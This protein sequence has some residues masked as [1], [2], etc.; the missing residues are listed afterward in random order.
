VAEHIRDFYHPEIDKQA[1]DMLAALDDPTVAAAATAG[2]LAFRAMGAKRRPD[3]DDGEVWRFHDAEGH[4]AEVEFRDPSAIGAWLADGSRGLFYSYTGSTEPLW[5]PVIGTTHIA[6]GVRTGYDESDALVSV[7]TA[8]QHG[9]RRMRSIGQ[10]VAW[11]IAPLRNAWAQMHWNPSTERTKEEIATHYDHD[12]E[13]YVG[14]E[15]VLGPW[16]QYSSG[17][18]LPGQREEEI[19]LDQLQE[20]KIDSLIRKLELEGADTLLEIGSGWGSLAIEIAKRSPHLHVTSL[21]VSHEQ[22]KLCEE[23]AVAA[24][25]ADQIDFR[26][27]DYR[28][29][30]PSE[31][32]DRIVS[33]EMIEAVDNKDLPVYYNALRDHLTPGIGSVTLQAITVRPSQEARQKHH[34]GFAQI[35]FPGGSLAA[36]R[37]IVRDM[38]ERELRLYE[39][40]DATASYGPTLRGWR[41]NLHEYAIPRTL[42]RK[43]QGITTTQ[44]A[45]SDRGYDLYFALSETGFRTRYIED[46]QLT[47]VNS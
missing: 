3:T 19:G 46:H 33:I 20:Q 18:L 25:V 17:L 38:E 23:A 14:D 2:R 1:H 10:G 28:D 7:T 40:T 16:K 22:R 36:R 47:F 41:Q 4:P 31:K 13:F 37:S 34:K 39:H 44:S 11:T 32:F 35:I 8:L 45:R 30:D 9:T 15:G 42:R 24:G 26:E 43:A 21:T 12:Q 6:D 5:R 29:L 27:Q